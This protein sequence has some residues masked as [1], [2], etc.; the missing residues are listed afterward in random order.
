MSCLDAKK[1]RASSIVSNGS[2]VGSPLRKGSK[3]YDKKN[4]PK[5]SKFSA[6]LDED[7]FVW[8]DATVNSMGI[9]DFGI[10]LKDKAVLP[11][12]S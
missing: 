1:Q 11:V 2:I 4:M 12:V 5:L 6:G 8:K 10:Y 3:T 9:S 7:Y